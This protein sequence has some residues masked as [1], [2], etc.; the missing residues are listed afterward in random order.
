M[1]GTTLEAEL[2]ALTGN[3]E[4]LRQAFQTQH[5]RSLAKWDAIM[6]EGQGTAEDRA[7]AFSASLKAGTLD[8]GKGDFAQLIADL[9][10]DS[11]DPFEVPSYLEDA[12]RGVIIEPVA[13]S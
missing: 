6:P 11:A 7:S 8:L 5:P 4:I 2:F 13:V 12:I 1:G 3:E 10:V 9:I